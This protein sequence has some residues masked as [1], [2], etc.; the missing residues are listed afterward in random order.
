MSTEEMKT[1]RVTKLQIIWKI[2]T[3]TQG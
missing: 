1:R 3:F 2:N